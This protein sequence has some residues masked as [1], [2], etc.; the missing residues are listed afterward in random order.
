MA[1]LWEDK[2]ADYYWS[3]P[4]LDTVA[5]LWTDEEN[6]SREHYIKVDE[7]DQQW[8]DFVKI[9]PYEKINERTEVRHESF[10][11]EFREAFR[12]WMVRPE[13]NM[14]EIQYVDR[15]AAP[16]SLIENIFDRLFAYDPQDTAQKEELF[17][18]KLKIFEQEIV[19]NSKSSDKFKKAK[20]FIRKAEN[21]LDVLLGY[22]VFTSEAELKL[23]PKEKFAVEGVYVPIKD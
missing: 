13:N 22:L 18:F 5:I 3:N 4:E 19:K 17:K 1:Y 7:T 21:P 16:L 23:S 10:R 8:N 11:E 14:T 20:T 12:L 15:P 9:V 6:I 2:I